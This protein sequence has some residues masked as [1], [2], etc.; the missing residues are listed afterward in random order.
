MNP[1]IMNSFLARVETNS[2]KQFMSGDYKGATNYLDPEFSEYILVKILERKGACIEDINALVT[3]LTRHELQCPKGT[4]EPKVQKR[5]QLMGSP[6]SFPV[7][8]I[9]NAML[10]RLALE[11]RESKDVKIPLDEAPMLVNGDDLGMFTDEFG[12][13]TWQKVTSACGLIPS[14][15][16]TYL[17]PSTMTINSELWHFKKSAIRNK[18]GYETEYW[19]GER[20]HYPMMGLVYGGES[21]VDKQVDWSD[22]EDH[23]K[24]R[25]PLKESKQSSSNG[26]R[27]TRSSWEKSNITIDNL[28]R[29]TSMS[30]GW[31]DFVKSCPNQNTA[32]SHMF[33]CNKD[34]VKQ[35]P[36]GMALCLP[37]WLAGAGIP[38]PDK[39]HLY[40]KERMPSH[41]QLKIAYYLMKH[42]E[43]IH[44]LT[45]ILSDSQL[46]AYLSAVMK[47]D[48]FVHKALYHKPE[49]DLTEQVY[50]S[51][52]AVA[53]P[54][55]PFAKGGFYGLGSQ[56]VY[57]IR[58]P[59]AKD[60]R[61]EAVERR[62]DFI[63]ERMRIYRRVQRF[64]KKLSMKDEK[65]AMRVCDVRLSEAPNIKLR[66]Y[67]VN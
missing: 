37:T 9:Y 29:I 15:G 10:S 11:L 18:H 24:S 14:V 58:L 36:M 3:A 28:G 50:R 56:D 39:T 34:F 2:R 45:S 13:W 59:S 64:R 55:V 21:K 31:T 41:N 8:C 1:E 42:P 48:S 16:K 63:V 23:L 32:W 4:F 19:T 30:S 44:N 51:R 33:N 53:E 57:D 66:K 43:E 61:L 62:H 5:G 26:W 60:R 27:I 65:K 20:S 22:V 67:V 17:H 38:L 40:Y 6:V 7:L 52:W 46:P 54:Q 35:L 47:T 12:F 49:I 25:N